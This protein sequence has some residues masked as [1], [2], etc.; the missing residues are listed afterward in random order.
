[1]SAYAIVG[2]EIAQAVAA[3]LRQRGMAGAPVWLAGPGQGATALEEAARVPADLLL[4]DI[5]TG[6]GLGP[7]VLRYRLARS[8]TRIVLLAAGK[9]PGDA[10]VAAAWE[11]FCAE[12]AAVQGQ[13][14]RIEIHLLP[15]SGHHLTWPP[16]YHRSDGEL[17][18]AC[19]GILA[20]VL[21]D[22]P[23][24]RGWPRF[25]WGKRKEPGPGGAGSLEGRGGAWRHTQ[26][27]T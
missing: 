21:P 19:T 10:E 18:R 24:R 23:E 6:P 14:A 8:Q 22:S 17:D 15:V 12:T 27:D 26:A 5:E 7:A 20:Q 25:P 2:R 11:A 9:V 4:L 1:M 3:C 13:G 16:G